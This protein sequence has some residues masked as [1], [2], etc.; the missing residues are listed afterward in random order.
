MVLMDYLDAVLPQMFNL[1]K[2]KKNKTL[3]VKYNKA[4]YACIS[5]CFHVYINTHHNTGE[6]YLLEYAYV[7]TISALLKLTHLCKWEHL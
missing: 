7:P 3:S 1:F 4:R 5:G 6:N 2:K